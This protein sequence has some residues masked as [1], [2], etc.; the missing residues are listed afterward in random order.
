MLLL[1]VTSGFTSASLH[2]CYH[3]LWP[4]CK[5]LLI[6]DS[7]TPRSVQTARG[8]IPVLVY[9]IRLFFWDSES[10]K[11]GSCCWEKSVNVSGK[12]GRIYILLAHVFLFQKS[13]RAAEL[14]KTRRV[15]LWL[16]TCLKPSAFMLRIAN[17][18]SRRERPL[19]LKAEHTVT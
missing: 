9:G 18:A 7:S 14:L 12:A 8:C 19:K 11:S 5:C 1:S 15:L 3:P 13:S 10:S 2:F 6:P 4:L 17:L 16:R